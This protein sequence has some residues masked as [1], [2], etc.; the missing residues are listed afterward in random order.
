MAAILELILLI[1][2]IVL[3][4]FTFNDILLPLLY[5]FPRVLLL[6]LRRYVMWRAPVFYLLSPIFWILFL[7]GMVSGLVSLAPEFSLY[8][9]RSVGFRAGLVIGMILP[10]GKLFIFKSARFQVDLQLYNSIRDYAKPKGV[11]SLATVILGRG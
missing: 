8:L 3:S 9:T 4:I 2:G 11:S 6:T 10:I 7:V 5:C 1:V